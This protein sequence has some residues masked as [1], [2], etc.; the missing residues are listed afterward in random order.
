MAGYRAAVALSSIRLIRAS[1][2]QA[3]RNDAAILG[4]FCHHRLVKRDILL[5]AA[6]GTSVHRQLVRQ[7]FPRGQAGIKV[8]QL[9]KVDDRALI[10]SSAA[11]GIGH[12]RKDRANVNLRQ[13]SGLWWC[14][15]G[16]SSSSRAG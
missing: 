7:F 8:E 11:L 6:V 14:A 4:Q 10:I 13:R 9:K 16:W 15:G 12:G 3:I 2:A 5:R 1:I